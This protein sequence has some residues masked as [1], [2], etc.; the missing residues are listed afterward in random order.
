MDSEGANF[1]SLQHKS[2]RKAV[3]VA[4]DATSGYRLCV[5]APQ[6]GIQLEQIKQSQQLQ[7]L[8]RRLLQP[9]TLS[10]IEY[11]RRLWKRK[12]LLLVQYWLCVAKGRKEVTAFGFFRHLVFLGS[13]TS[14]PKFFFTYLCCN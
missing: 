1:T 12:T 8:W 10:M 6:K 14:C 5:K 2:Y 9:K 3:D 11:Q 7:S 13:S 4:V